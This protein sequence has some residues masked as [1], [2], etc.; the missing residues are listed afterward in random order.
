MNTF[1]GRMENNMDLP[2]DLHPT[3][4]E[5]LGATET[6]F[7]AWLTLEGHFVADENFEELK[8]AFWEDYLDALEWGEKVMRSDMQYSYL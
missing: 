5:V 6:G 2:S 4:A 1:L 8:E 7:R 3:R